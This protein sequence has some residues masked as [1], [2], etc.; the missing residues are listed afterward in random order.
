MVAVVREFILTNP[1]PD[2]A[3]KCSGL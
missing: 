2:S 1:A 3:S